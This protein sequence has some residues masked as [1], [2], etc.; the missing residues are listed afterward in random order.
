VVRGVF[1]LPGVNELVGIEL[2]DRVAGS[3]IATTLSFLGAYSLVRGKYGN[4]KLI[5]SV[6]LPP[7]IAPTIITAVAL[8]LYFTSVPLELVGS[9]ISLRI[10]T[11]PVCQAVNS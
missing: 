5:I 10:W 11:P 2:S 9:K 8:C 6:C 7:L 4:K 3:V 1:F